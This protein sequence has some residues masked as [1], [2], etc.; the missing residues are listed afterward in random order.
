MGKDWSGGGWI[1]WDKVGD[2]E[3]NLVYCNNVFKAGPGSTEVV[4]SD[5][6]LKM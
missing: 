1:G 5:S 2:K 6:L 4:S 3:Y